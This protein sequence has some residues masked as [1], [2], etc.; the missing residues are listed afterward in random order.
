[1]IM[2][3]L[4]TGSTSCLLKTLWLMRLPLNLARLAAFI[5]VRF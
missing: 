1:M 3:F 5:Q 2:D 4:I